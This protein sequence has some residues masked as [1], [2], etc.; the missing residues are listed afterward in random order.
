MILLNNME[1]LRIESRANKL[2]EIILL[3]AF[4]AVFSIQL[5]GCHKVLQSCGE[6]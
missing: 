6:G 1:L 5:L 2:L 3:A 4:V